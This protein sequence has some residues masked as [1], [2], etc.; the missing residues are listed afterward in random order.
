VLSWLATHTAAS[1]TQGG[2]LTAPG[3]TIA[4]TA[5]AGGVVGSAT[6]TLEI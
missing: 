4:V 1:I 6:V 5:S 2:L 3:T